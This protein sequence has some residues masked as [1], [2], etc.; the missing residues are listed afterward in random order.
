MKYTDR[1][2]AIALAG[3]FQAANLVQ[4]IAH[5]G[6]IDQ[7]SLETCISSLFKVDA[8]TPEA[9]FGAAANL[10]LGYKTLL[11]Q[12][13]G[14]NHNTDKPRDID[15]TKYVISIAVLE[16]KLAKRGDLLKKITDGIES[17]Q[18]QLEHF[19]LT[20]DNVL[21]KLAHIYS[22][23]I[24]TLKPRIM[25]NGEHQHISNPNQANKIRA[26][27]LAGIRA[28]V[29]WRQCG[30]TRWQLLLKRNV[31]LNQTKSLLAEVQV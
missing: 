16:R 21:A 15:I 26:L 13:G 29:L 14:T 31:V 7:Q 2:R 4:Q 1:D 22:E 20:H 28:A 23:T 8:D 30:G 18:L 9:V 17:T 3:I 19:G 5:T 25:V 10:T 27:L 24:S 11:T 6:M 12:L